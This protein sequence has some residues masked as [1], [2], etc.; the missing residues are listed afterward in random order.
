[1][2]YIEA[3]EFD[4]QLNEYIRKIAKGVKSNDTESVKRH[5]LAMCDFNTSHLITQGMAATML[6]MSRAAL[7]SWMKRNMPNVGIRS[8]NGRRSLYSLNEFMII[9]QERERRLK[10]R[11][12]AKKAKD[13]K[14]CSLTN[15]GNG[16]KSKPTKSKMKTC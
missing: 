2:H 3:E 13:A 15:K 7:N 8:D 11:E 4:R 5:A 1:M 12:L 14:I 9:K 6:G 16:S 10:A